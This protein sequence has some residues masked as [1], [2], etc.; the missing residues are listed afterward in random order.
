VV[1]MI[2]LSKARFL[3]VGEA[4]ERLLGQLPAVVPALG[5]VAEGLT[6]NGR[7]RVTTLLTSIKKPSFLICLAI[8]TVAIGVVNI[9]NHA[10]QDKALNFSSYRLELKLMLRELK[11]QKQQGGPGALLRNRLQGPLGEIYQLEDNDWATM[12]ART[13]RFIDILLDRLKKRLPQLKILCCFDVFDI[14]TW[15]TDPA[16]GIDNIKKLFRHFLAK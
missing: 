2:D 1:E 12:R 4:T 14:S 13:A 6:G 3:N 7:T 15:T 9:G 8:E 10:F 5:L 11:L 16:F